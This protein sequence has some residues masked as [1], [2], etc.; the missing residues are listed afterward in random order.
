MDG[1]VKLWALGGECVL[2]IVVDAKIEWVQLREKDIFM[3]VNGR[4]SRLDG[5]YFRRYL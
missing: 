2:D 3:S 5:A 1:T 4:L